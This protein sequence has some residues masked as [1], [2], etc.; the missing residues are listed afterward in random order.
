MEITRIEIDKNMGFRFLILFIIITSIID[1]MLLDYFW[2][3]KSMFLKLKG[4]ILCLFMFFFSFF[5]MVFYNVHYIFI[6][7]LLEIILLRVFIFLCWFFILTF[8]LRGLF[9][10][11]LVMV[12]IGGFSISLLVSV[13]RFFGRDFWYFRFVF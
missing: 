5:S 10:F 12:C 7:L 8:G 9:V 2:I 4:I 1:D 13:S 11:L 6:L 3:T